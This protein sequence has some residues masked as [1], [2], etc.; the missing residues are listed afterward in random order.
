[1]GKIKSGA[2]AAAV[3]A[4]AALVM[5]AGCDKPAPVKVSAAPPVKFPVLDPVANPPLSSVQPYERK[6]FD[7]FGARA[8]AVAAG[9]DKSRMA[10]GM[11]G[12]C[13]VEVR[14]VTLALQTLQVARS[15]D[16]LVELGAGRYAAES[17]IGGWSEEGIKQAETR[18]AAAEAECARELP[19]MAASHYHPAYD[20]NFAE[21][22]VARSFVLSAYQQQ[23]EHLGDYAQKWIM[24]SNPATDP[25]I[26]R[27]L[28][29][30]TS[31]W[32]Q[33]GL[34]S[35]DKGEREKFSE[36]SGTFFSPQ[37]FICP[38]AVPFI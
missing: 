12:S 25:K 4:F 37:D 38:P 27:A 9:T 19:L 32:R 34:Q 15:H 36:V 1:M 6:M 18:L 10:P 20:I 11:T 13:M 21:G 24:Q 31:V 8:Q 23:T 16:A 35:S 5:V 3:A 14:E 33:I 30:L 7:T 29:G 26:C 22:R 2:A 28:D 17:K